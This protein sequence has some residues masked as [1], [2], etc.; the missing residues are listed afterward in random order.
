MNHI[1]K[2]LKTFEYESWSDLTSSLFPSI[3]Y[4]ISAVV[5]ST[6]ALSVATYKIFGLNIL[7]TIAFVLVLTMEVISGIIAS[8]VAGISV[9]STKSSR[10]SLKMACYLIMLFVSNSF[11]ESFNV[12]GS[13]VGYWFFDWLHLFLAVHIA[14][15]NII[16]IGENLGVIN[17]KGK[18][19]W[20]SQIQDKVNELFRVKKD[21]NGI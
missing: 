16:S 4:N 10:F 15:E 3:K 5:L 14:T 18:T 8:K 9:S 12:K 7:A 11:A 13:N 6:S 2:L 1:N 19:Y 21:N 20:I 17:G